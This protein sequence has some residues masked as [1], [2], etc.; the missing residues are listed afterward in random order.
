MQ[1][2]FKYKKCE[3]CKYFL[4]HYIKKSSSFQ[5]VCCGHCINDKL[6][7]SRVKNKYAL[8]ENCEFWEAVEDKSAERAES[9]REA[10]LNMQER[11]RD[12]TCILKDDEK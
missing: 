8:H 10:L 1:I 2:D 11:L 7:G 9:I 6:N 3:S 12:I 4:Q 5:E